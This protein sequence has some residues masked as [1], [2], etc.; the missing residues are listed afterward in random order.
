MLGSHHIKSGVLLVIKLAVFESMFCNGLKKKNGLNHKSSD[1]EGSC[2]RKANGADP[3]C[4]VVCVCVCVC[5][6]FRCEYI[7]TQNSNTNVDPDVNVQS[8]RASVFK[9][10][11]CQFAS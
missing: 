10:H 1:S 3:I 2:V 9:F 8:I 11:K 6:S 5:D 7:Y 4:T